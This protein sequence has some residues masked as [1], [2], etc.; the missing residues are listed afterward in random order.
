MGT[1]PNAKNFSMTRDDFDGIE[2]AL[3]IAA[4]LLITLA[5]TLLLFGD[6]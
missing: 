1:A 6:W 4:A 5:M 2:A 3:N